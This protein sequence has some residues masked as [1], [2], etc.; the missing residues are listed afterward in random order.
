V[1]HV[2]R[3]HKYIEWWNML[4]GYINVLSGGTCSYCI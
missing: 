4:L 1:E 2:D 3:L